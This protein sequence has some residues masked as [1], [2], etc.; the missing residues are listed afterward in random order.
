MVIVSI[1]NHERQ[2][3]NHRLEVMVEEVKSNEV[4]PLVLEH[5]ETWEGLVSFT[6]SKVGNNQDVEFALYRDNDNEPW[7]KPFHLLVNAEE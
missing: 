7:L 6:L 1:V 3:I 2:T 5:D 4:G